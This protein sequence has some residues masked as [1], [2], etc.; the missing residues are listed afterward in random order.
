MDVIYLPLARKA[1][2]VQQQLPKPPHTHG[3]FDQR[4]PLRSSLAHS[5]CSCQFNL[6]RRFPPTHYCL[7]PQFAKVLITKI[8]LYQFVKVFTRERFTLYASSLVFISTAVMTATTREQ[9]TSGVKE[10][11]PLWRREWTG[12]RNTFHVGFVFREMDPT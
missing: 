10:K 3:S 8:R 9:V 5:S 6:V 7:F 11:P 1:V 4:S 2:F 12:R